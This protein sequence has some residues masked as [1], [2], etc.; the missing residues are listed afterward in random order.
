MAMSDDLIRRQELLKLPRRKGYAVNGWEEYIRVDDI[1]DLPS[2]QPRKG[3][4]IKTDR[5]DEVCDTLCECSECHSFVLV[6]EDYKYCPYC[7]ADMR[8]DAE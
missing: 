6:E 8:G 2:V 7:G 1:K 4:W 3:K 5:W